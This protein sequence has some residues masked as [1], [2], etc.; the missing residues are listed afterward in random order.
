[1]SSRHLWE[2]VRDSLWFLPTALTVA[3]A[4][5][6]PLM[7][8]VDTRWLSSA[9]VREYWWSSAARRRGLAACWGR[10]PGA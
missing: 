1:M 8:L 4:V 7:V 6:A 10:S 9:E 2:R 3:G 5:L